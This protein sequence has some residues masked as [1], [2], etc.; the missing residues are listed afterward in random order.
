M[1][2]R[3]KRNSGQFIEIVK[4]IILILTLQQNN[5]SYVDEFLILHSKSLLSIDLC[6]LL[7]LGHAFLVMHDV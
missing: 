2:I 3:F 4:E 5:N 7:K 6:I 1:P